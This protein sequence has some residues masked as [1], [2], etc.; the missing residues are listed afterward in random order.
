MLVSHPGPKPTIVCLCGS[1]KFHREM[2]EVA[3]KETL[4]GRIVLIVGSN[5]KSDDELNLTIEQR[6]RLEALHFHKI[7][8]AE[9]IL[10]VNVGG[11]IGESTSKEIIYANSMGKNIRFYNLE[12]GEI[13]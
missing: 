3:L 5:D 6:K 8:M 2:H 4:E 7:D 11:Y 13:T 9:E 1:T 10:V 12:N